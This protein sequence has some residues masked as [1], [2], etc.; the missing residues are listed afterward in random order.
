[1]GTPFLPRI[2][3][4]VG[5]LTVGH[6]GIPYELKKFSWRI[7]DTAPG[8]GWRAYPEDTPKIEPYYWIGYPGIDFFLIHRPWARLPD[9]GE[10]GP[11]PGDIV[12]YDEVLYRLTKYDENGWFGRKVKDP[13]DIDFEYFLKDETQ[14]EFVSR[15]ENNGD[16][17]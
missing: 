4:Q 5:I 6:T 13:H 7:V 2:G 3:D 9:L 11:A 10:I 12:A 8:M 14:F 17:L 16:D 1:M 15:G